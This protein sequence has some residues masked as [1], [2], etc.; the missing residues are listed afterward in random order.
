MLR[1]LTLILCLV[2]LFAPAAALAQDASPF[3][4]L[5]P[6]QTTPAPTPTVTAAS[7]STGGGGLKSWQTTLIVAAGGILLLGIA[8]AIVSDA[9]RVAPAGDPTETVAESRSRQEADL[10]R[11]KARNRQAAKRAR[12][13][14]KKNRP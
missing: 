12:E 13:S 7:S 1:R 2:A 6:A 14:R 4:P 8:W 9:R 3:S 10:K 11:R 5:P